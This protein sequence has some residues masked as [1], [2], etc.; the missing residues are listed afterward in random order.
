MKK[1]LLLS[2]FLLSL[3]ACEKPALGTLTGSV[4]RPVVEGF[5]QPGSTPVVQVKKQLAYGSTDS[6]QLPVEGLLLQIGDP[7]TGI[8]YTLTHTDSS[9]YMADGSWTPVAG[10]T[11][12]LAFEYNN[13]AVTAETTVPAKP[14]DFTTSA[15]AIAA[16]VF[17]GGTG[18]PPTFPDPVELNWDASDGGYYLV[19]VQVAETDPELIFSDTTNFR[20]MRAFRSEPQQTN[21]WQLQPFSFRY[22]GKHHVILYRL[23][24]E[25]AAL[26]ED[27]GSN[28]NN[29]TTPFT[30]ISG[31]L[32]IF[33]GVNADTLTV[34]VTK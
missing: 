1:I 26:Y 29:L 27:T 8:W 15:V 21:T 3:A 32:G 2:L 24:P 30:N 33:T 9:A 28:S 7:E 20:P 4:N 11:Y 22:Y 17:G 23:N 25:Y 19:V 34:E 14:G 16:P 18:G 6:V 12:Q 13:A 31:G 5:L 10:K